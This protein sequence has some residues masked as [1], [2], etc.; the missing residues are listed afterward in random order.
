MR[1]T[2]ATSNPLK[3]L[4]ALCWEKIK[5]PSQL[6][7]SELETITFLLSTILDAPSHLG[8]GNHQEK[9]A[10]PAANDNHRVP[11]CAI[12]QAMHLDA[13]NSYQ[14]MNQSSRMSEREM[15][16]LIRMYSQKKF[17]ESEQE[18]VTRLK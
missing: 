13:F 17:Q 16:M 18:S 14:M 9:Q 1:I 10:N 3:Y 8:G 5:N 4:L 15:A 12:T 6:P 2:Q 11:L 7:R